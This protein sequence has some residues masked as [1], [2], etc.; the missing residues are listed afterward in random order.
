MCINMNKLTITF[1]ISFS[2]KKI[3]LYGT[4]EVPIKVKT[5]KITWGVSYGEIPVSK[6]A[7]RRYPI[8]LTLKK[9]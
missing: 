5:L 7:Q 9:S 3:K 8:N 2:I 4:P 6:N 1:T